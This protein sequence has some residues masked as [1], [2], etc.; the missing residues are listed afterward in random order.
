MS[1]Y[2]H[3]KTQKQIKEYTRTIIDKINVCNDIKNIYPEH[4]NYFTTFLFPRHTEY[5]EKF[6]NM[7]NIGICKNKLF[8]N[9]EVYIVKENGSIDDVSALR[10]C[11]SG[12]KSNSLSNA[13][14]CSIYPQIQNFKENLLELKCV[15][16]NST[17]NIH[18]D[19]SSPQFIDLQITFIQTCDLEIPTLFDDNEWNGK[20]F[21]NINE[22]F[23]KKWF[24]YHENNSNLQ[25][26]CKKCNLTKEK[27]KN[28]FKNK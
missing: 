18:I 21:K 15:E 17:K 4:Y 13:M 2:N 23:E 3:L 24:S 6:V 11:V 27:S 1:E 25:P 20:I 10:N 22:N 16:C 5:P 19:H 28:K 7:N 8:N 9:L 26:L 12:N 14:R